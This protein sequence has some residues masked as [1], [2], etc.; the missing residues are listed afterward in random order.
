MNEQLYTRFYNALI[1]EDDS[2]LIGIRFHKRIN[3][4]QYHQLLILL[5]EVKEEFED[6]EMIPKK[7]AGLFTDF[8]AAI[9]SSQSFY[10]EQE[11]MEIEEIAD[12]IMYKFS[13]ILN[14]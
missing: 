14:D 2:L 7:Y 13:V 4:E 6:S 3:R 12:K 9:T 5:D 8:Y 1:G 11:Q 10:S